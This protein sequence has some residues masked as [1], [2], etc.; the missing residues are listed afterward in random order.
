MSDAADFFRQGLARHQ[1][2]DAPGAAALY[3]KGLALN[4]RSP[5]A[6]HLLGVALFQTNDVS[7]A[8]SAL[9][10]AVG[11]K[12]AFA[13]A[14]G[15]LG[16]ALQS[17]GRFAEAEI[18]LRTAISQAPATA[19]FHFNLGN[20]LAALKR[21]DSAAGA[22]REAVRLQ[23]H[24]PEAHSNLGSVLRDLE[25]VEAATHAFETAVAQK[26]DYV[27]ARYNL[28]NAYRDLG[29]LTHAETEMR[30]VLAQRASAKAYN[31]LGVILSDQGRSAD[32]VGAFAA[33]MTHDPSYMPAASNWLS[34]QQYVTGVTE[35]SLARAHAQWAA[36]H[37]PAT[38]PAAPRL[39]DQTPLTLGF[40]SPDLGV[41]PV[42]LLSVRMFENLEP[43]RVRAI[44]FSTRPAPQ[45]DVISARIRAVTDWRRVDGMADDTLARMIQDAGVQ[46]LFDLSGH[47][48]GHRLGV[49]ACKPAPVQISWLG[50][51][52]T[53]GLAVMD[54]VLADD[55]QAPPAAEAHYAEKIIRLSHA[56]ACFD[57]PA[58]AAAATEPPAAR[59]GFI[60]FGSLNNPAKLSDAAIASMSAI[61]ERVPSSRLLLKFR[62]LEDDGVRKRLRG[63]LAAHGI[64]AERVHISGRA[65]RAEFLTTYNE[66]D[67]A[68]DTF[69]YSGGLTTCEALWM[70]CPVVT[71]PGATFAGRHAAS[72][73][74]HAGLGDLVAQDRAGFE[75]LAATLASDLPRLHRLRASL[76]GQ[77]KK[78]I[79]DGARFAGAFTEAMAKAWRSHV[80]RF[81]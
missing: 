10:R 47:T 62:G 48:A 44:V 6:W 51:V 25:H 67:I 46:I 56:Y 9:E 21:R 45:E 36:R 39:K 28:A 19:A 74:T 76:R 5:D 77:V 38:V 37:G 60:T 30:K 4:D 59:N 3:R 34:A 55:V 43:R 69:P 26:P 52:G 13:E 23:P 70:G 32:A 35:D 57:P 31:A 40:V 80:D 61:L 81:Q 41:H 33:A 65:P 1:A 15:N 78:S 79:C 49:F 42:G 14:H 27:E 22:Y 24:Y 12:P 71:F 53:T 8:I 16:T 2:G 58:D 11:L 75:A 73:L 64:G 54:Y 66:I 63:A 68:L 17:A 20:L 18:A 72:Y 7:A 50:Y 29:R